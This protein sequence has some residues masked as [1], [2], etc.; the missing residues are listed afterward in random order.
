[1][2]REANDFVAREAPWAFFANSQAPEAWA[3]YVKS[4]RPHPVYTM[5]LTETWLDL[6]RKRVA[7]L[8]GDAGPGQGVKDARR[9]KV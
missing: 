2:Y 8:D 6:P 3:P 5:Y 9:E 1:M 4:Y 7:S